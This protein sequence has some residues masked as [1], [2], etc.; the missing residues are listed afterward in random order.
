CP[1]DQLRA[2]LFVSIERRAVTARVANSRQFDSNDRARSRT[3]IEMCHEGCVI[4]IRR[5]DR[6][7]CP[8]QAHGLWWS[9]KRAEHDDD[10]SILT[11]VRDG[12]D[13]ASDVIDIGDGC[14]P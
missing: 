4:G 14:R 8:M 9:L 6:A 7:T 5:F 11:K 12:F 3:R 13:T 1:I 10:S 2:L